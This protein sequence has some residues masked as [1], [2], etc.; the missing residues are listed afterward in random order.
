MSDSTKVVNGY[1]VEQVDFGYGTKKLGAYFQTGLNEWKETNIEG[2][3]TFEFA[4]TNRDQWSVYLHDS[5]RKVNIQ[6]DLHRKKVLY[7]DPNTSIRD[8]YDIFSSAAVDGWLI[9]EGMFGSLKGSD[10][11]LGSYFQTG[12]TSWCERNAEGKVTFE[13]KEVNR[14]DWSV[15]LL[16]SSREVSIQIDSWTNKIF[17]SDPQTPRREQYSLISV[18]S[19]NGW[20]TRKATFGE[21]ADT[22]GRYRQERTSKIWQELDNNG[23]VAFNFVEENRDECRAI[24]LKYL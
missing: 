21:G 15:Y 8:Q 7:S 5:S 16:D 11:Q 10:T 1:R 3:T 24:A 22:F 13:F 19:V 9:A 18:T 17:Y 4:E 14:D 12:P 23:K 20:I 6:I 2:K